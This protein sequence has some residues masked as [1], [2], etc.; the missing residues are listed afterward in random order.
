MLGRTKGENTQRGA[1]GTNCSL[2]PRGHRS[3]A[4]GGW[5]SEV[6][7]PRDCAV[8]PESC[9]LWGREGRAHTSIPLA[10]TSC[11]CVGPGISSRPGWP[12]LLRWMTT[13]WVASHPSPCSTLQSRGGRGAT[14]RKVSVG[15]GFDVSKPGH[16]L[17]CPPEVT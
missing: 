16:H 13:V 15:A 7:H 2:A 8:C 14:S 10:G 3:E 5:Q 12:W 9:W 17:P 11:C 1:L 4:E 6:C